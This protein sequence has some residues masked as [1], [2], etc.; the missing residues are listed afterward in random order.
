MTFDEGQDFCRAEDGRDLA[1]FAEMSEIHYILSQLCN[2][3][4]VEGLNSFWIGMKQNNDSTWEWTDQSTVD[5]TNWA[6][7]GIRFNFKRE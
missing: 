5:F 1:S 3:T 4:S 6:S 7:S 2:E